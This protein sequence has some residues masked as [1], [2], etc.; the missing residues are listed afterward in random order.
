[1][2]YY[3]KQLYIITITKQIQQQKY[4]TNKNAEKKIT[5]YKTHE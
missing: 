5:V 3:K 2:H 4:D 1:M